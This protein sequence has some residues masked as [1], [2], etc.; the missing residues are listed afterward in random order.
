MT[1]YRTAYRHSWVKPVI[2]LFGIDPRSDEDWCPDFTIPAG[3][4]KEGFSL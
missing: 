3:S 4:I 2:W 1:T